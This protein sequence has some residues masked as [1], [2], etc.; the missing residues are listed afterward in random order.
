MANWPIGSCWAAMRSLAVKISPCLLA[1]SSFPVLAYPAE[2]PSAGRGVGDEPCPPGAIAVA[3]GTS[4]QAAVDSAGEHATF[5]L[6]NGI[7]RM[8][9]I[10]PQRG[11]TFH[12]EGRTILNGSRLLTEFI[13]EGPYWV[14]TGQMQRGQVR[15]ECASYAPACSRPEAVFIDD[16]PL[17]QV[18]NKENVE[19][20]RFYLEYATGKLYLADDPANRK[21]E[22]TRAA[23]AF[24]STAGDVLI[25]NVTVEKYASAAQ[26]GAIHAREGS[27]WTLENSEVRLNSGAGISIGDGGRVLD[28]DIHHNG[29]IGIEG[30]GP[31]IWIENNRIWANN[32][33]GFDYT[34]QAGGV[35]IALS[36]GVTFRGNHVHDNIGPG[37]WCDINCHNVVYEDNLV[38]RNQGTGIFH[39][40]SFNAIIRDNV[41]RHNGPDYRGWFWDADILISASQDVDV[42]RNKLTVRMDGCGIVLIDQSRPI[43]RGGSY[44][45]RNIDQNRSI[46]GGKYKTRNNTIH[47]N[48]TTF[49]GAICAGGVSDTKPDD[50]NFTI[51]R[52]GNNRFDWNLYRVPRTSDPAR[53]VWGHD[54][55][56]WEGFRRKGL[57]KNGRL[58]R[59]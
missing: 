54:I 43:E 30:H 56:D 7:H 24:E 21:V 3:P 20:N 48:E 38:E 50:E 36:D 26:K 42:Y 1:L 9:A 46:A 5:C 31:D 28:C 22:V 35:K 19:A 49:E 39:E 44:K 8:Q 18:L 55:S 17:E 13:R 47:Y 15:G 27:R 41:V 32:I 16:M 6:K 37:L 34:W 23:F 10:R 29:Q 12:G 25:R 58:V 51:I 52:D 4:I 40:I 57:E 11:Q 2:L 53:F 14:A 33:Y 59:F 45:T